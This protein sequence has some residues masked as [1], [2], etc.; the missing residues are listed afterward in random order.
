MEFFHR[1]KTVPRSV[2]ILSSA[3]NPPTQAHLALAEAALAVVDE[4]LFVLPRVFPHQKTYSDLTVEQRGDLLEAAFADEPRFS[5]AATEGGLFVEIAE[6][7]RG[8]YGEGVELYVLCG[9]D[10]AERI[11]NWDYGRPGAF[12]DQL[13]V[14]QL[15]VA[16]R[17]GDYQPPPEF[18]GRIHALALRENFDHVSSTEVRR[19]IAAGEPWE[20]LTPAAARELISRYLR[21]TRTREG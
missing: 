17:Q 18:A 16:S 14:F 11:V 8:A 13:R 20:H 19:C 1:A 10:V 7:C 6:E 15:L 5:I 12:A 3:F 9:R 21:A 2:A 4:V